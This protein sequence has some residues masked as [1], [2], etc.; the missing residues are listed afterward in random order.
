MNNC[1]KYQTLQP[2]ITLF[3]LFFA[4][5]AILI[6]NSVLAKTLRIHNSNETNRQI[7]SLVAFNEPK[8]VLQKDIEFSPSDIAVAVVTFKGRQEETVQAIRDTWGS[9]F[10]KVE[11]VSCTAKE[12]LITAVVPEN[13]IY[14]RTSWEEMNSLRILH[15]KYPD[16]PWYMK[17]DD[18]A[19]VNVKA[20]V[21]SLKGYDTNQVHYLGQPMKFKKHKHNYCAGGVGY[22]LSNAAMKK[23]YSRLLE[24]LKSCCSDVQVGRLLAEELNIST[25]CTGPEGFL[26]IAGTLKENIISS[27]SGKLLLWRAEKEDTKKVL[28]EKVVGFHYVNA[29]MQYALRFFYI[30]STCE[31]QLEC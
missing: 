10:P 29:Q 12:G 26:Y 18:D 4:I 19:Y 3:L 5:T 15:E 24:P 8:T 16:S 6:P 7:Y 13:S 14:E 23:I 22:I 28:I 31:S 2:T 30:F 20:L 9:D 21:K 11:Y 1:W 25:P 17:T 27:V